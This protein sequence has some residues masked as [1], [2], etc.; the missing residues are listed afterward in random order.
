MRKL[1]FDRYLSL[2]NT[3]LLQLEKEINFII[4]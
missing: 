4:S 3:E 2:S 1:L